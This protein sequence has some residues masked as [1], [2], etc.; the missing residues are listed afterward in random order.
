M[1]FLSEQAMQEERRKSINIRVVP[2]Q[3]AGSFNMLKFA[4]D[5]DTRLVEVQLNLPLPKTNLFKLSADEEVKVCSL[6]EWVHS[7]L[8][9]L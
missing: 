7:V 8:S 4:L 5:E 9:S 6:W 1:D 2:V 3:V